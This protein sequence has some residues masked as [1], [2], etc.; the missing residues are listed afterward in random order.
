MKNIRNEENRKSIREILSNKVNKLS[1]LIFGMFII[2]PVSI[3]GLF[4]NGSVV[5]DGEILKETSCIPTST[6][7][8]TNTTTSI[9]TTSTYVTSLKT[10]HTTSTKTTSV[11]TCVKTITQKEEDEVIEQDD[12]VYI[13]EEPIELVEESYTQNT[14]T[15]EVPVFFV[16]KPSTKYVHKSNCRWVDDSCYEITDTSNIEARKCTECNPDIEIVSVYVEPEI[17]NTVT[18]TDGKTSLNYVTESERIML[19]NVVGGEYG[20]DWV[21]LYDKA[22]VVAC[23]MNR[24]YDGGW[25][26][27]DRE[28]SI[29][30]VITAPGQF[31]YYYANTSYNYNVTDSCIEAVEYYFENQALFPH[32][33]TFCGD[34]TRNYFS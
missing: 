30:N 13:K 21:S 4:S 2:I 14:E 22:C 31:A 29:Y 11:T 1:G 15:D 6:D 12:T 10:S 34:G 32:Y 3:F 27:Y 25:Q 7:I 17:P 26:G 24:Y 18:N 28:N 33:T 5:G 20:S 9:T 8:T 16:Y 23:V 19:C